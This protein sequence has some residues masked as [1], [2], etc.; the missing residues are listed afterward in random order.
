MGPDEPV[1]KDEVLCKIVGQLFLDGRFLIEKLTREN[2]LLRQ[3]LV[4]AQQEKE[5]ALRLVASRGVAP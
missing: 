2:V 3:E 4:A 5:D 1:N